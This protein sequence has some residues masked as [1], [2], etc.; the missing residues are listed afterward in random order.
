MAQAL[1]PVILT[2]ID[3]S[4]GEKSEDVNTDVNWS[5]FSYTWT[6]VLILFVEFVM[7]LRRDL[8]IY[9]KLNTIGVLGIIILMVY[10]LVTG[11]VGIAET[12]YTTNKHEYD[13]YLEKVDSGISTPY[14]AYIELFA[15]QYARLMGILG[16]G[17]Y[18]HNISLPIIA[19]NPNP[20][21]NE[22]DLFIGYFM[23]FLTYITFGIVGYL[24]FSA[25]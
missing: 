19:R 4:T 8:D 23:V 9:I 24:G 25:E 17:F 2:F 15:S 7:T 3:L 12:D 11:L 16:G 14:L 18:L 10:I 5:S 21:T 1:Y 6:C 13:E 22:R 20:K